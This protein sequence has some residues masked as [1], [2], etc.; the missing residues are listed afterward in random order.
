MN[1]SEKVTEYL[2]AEENNICDDCLSKLLNIKP[3]QQ[4]NQICNKFKDNNI[5]LRIK[6]ECKICKSLKIINSLNYDKESEQSFK[7]ED[8][9]IEQTYFSV[10]E[11]KSRYDQ[12][13]Y[14][15]DEKHKGRQ[16]ILKNCCLKN[17]LWKIKQKSELIESVLMGLQ[18]SVIYF[19]EDR[20]GNLSIVDG[21]QRLTALFQFL[22]GEYELNNLTIMKNINGKNFNELKPLYQS[23]L[24][25]YQVIT[26]VIKPPIPEVIISKIIDR[27]NR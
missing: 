4:I 25:D 27:L 19:C 13:R 22:D 7:V 21:R 5:L 15:S 6:G 10:H 2:K 18:I 12:S 9:N 3:R 23:K 11:L 1:N 20:F 8:V 17:N 26:Q 16:I 24:E 14:H